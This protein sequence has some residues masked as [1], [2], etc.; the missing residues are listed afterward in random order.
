MGKITNLPQDTSPSGSD[1]T[2]T[3]ETASG[4]T[5]KVLLSDMLTYMMTGSFTG[6]LAY[7][8]ISTL[9]NPYKFSAYSTSTAASG[10]AGWTKKLYATEDTDTN[11]N[12]ASSTYTVPVSGFYLFGGGVGFASSGANQIR[13]A[14]IYW[15]G[16]EYQRG[17]EI[18]AP[19]T[20]NVT[21]GV[22]AL[23]RCSAGDRI[24]LW[25]YSAA[26]VNFIGLAS[27][28]VFWGFLVSKT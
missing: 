28:D 20:M 16:L 21:V 18:A 14:S 27:T 25:Y 8:A 26:S 7:D 5:K 3:V 1:Y 23:V 13:I 12:Y 22:T 24:E 4:Q 6:N 2:V 10:T 19:T 9:S 15:N 17:T 11:N